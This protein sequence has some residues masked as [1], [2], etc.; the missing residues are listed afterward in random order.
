MIGL[1]A[2]G[3]VALSASTG[4]V[5]L[6]TTPGELGETVFLAGA[7]GQ[8]G[9][10]V[11]PTREQALF[12]AFEAAHPEMSPADI[13][14]GAYAGAGALEARLE[15]ELAEIRTTADMDVWAA[16]IATRCDAIAVAFPDML[17]RTADTPTIWAGTKATLARRYV[18]AG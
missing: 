6:A 13:S 3:A 12:E 1:L 15:A 17:S 18:P 8:F 14:A 7:C 5:Q 10:A 4:P 16:A 9:W 2:A 11:D